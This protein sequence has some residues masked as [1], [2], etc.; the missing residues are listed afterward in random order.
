M[1]KPT[2]PPT[3]PRARVVVVRQPPRAPKLA[4]RESR[5]APAAERIARC[6]RASE[7]MAAGLGAMETARQLATEAGISCRQAKRYVARVRARWAEQ[8]AEDRPAHRAHVV[9]FLWATARA[10][11]EAGDYGPA[12]AAAR[13]IAKVTG[14][15]ITTVVTAGT[16]SVH[17]AIEAALAMT[18]LEREAEIARIEAEPPN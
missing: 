4:P 3:K 1:K 7:L 6:W 15:E 12:V 18:P 9:R 2:K 16:T 5:Q 14:L 13:A 17:Q 10:A 11:R 8:E